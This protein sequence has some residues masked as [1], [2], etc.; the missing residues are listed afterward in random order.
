MELA[1]VCGV[2]GCRELGG[3]RNACD[4][5]AI[6]TNSSDGRERMGVMKGD[7][8]RCSSLG[9]SDV[10]QVPDDGRSRVLCQDRAEA[11][12]SLHLLHRKWPAFSN[13]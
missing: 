10:V 4:E 2:C 8:E 6:V 1:E 11:S 7:I 9:Q 5:M 13:D 12:K 3:G